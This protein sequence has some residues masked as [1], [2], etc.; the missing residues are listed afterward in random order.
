MGFEYLDNLSEDAKKDL[1]Q[2]IINKADKGDLDA[3]IYLGGL[4]Q[5][6]YM[7]K[8][9]IEKAVEV[10]KKAAE[11]GSGEAMYYLYTV[12]CDGGG[13]IAPDEKLARSYLSDSLEKGYHAAYYSAGRLYEFGYIGEDSKAAVE[14]YVKGAILG[15][16]AC[17]F[18]CGLIYAEGKLVEFDEEK[19]VTMIKA[20]AESGDEEAQEYIEKLEKDK[21]MIKKNYSEQQMYLKSFDKMLE[22]AN[23]DDA[24]AMFN[25]AKM[26]QKGVGVPKNYGKAVDWYLKALQEG[27][28]EAGFVLGAMYL[29][30]Q[31]SLSEN[32]EMA[33]SC[34]ES[35]AEKGHAR[36]MIGI[37][38]IYY[39]AYKVVEQ[40][41]EKASKYHGRAMQ[42]NDPIALELDVKMKQAK[43]GQEMGMLMFNTLMEI[44][45]V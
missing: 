30:G 6:G 12:Y 11:Q 40:D 34:W 38:V 43:T 10:W 23:A 7:V 27:N 36:A 19:A 2:T 32:V 18:R 8:R 14:L 13:Q 39:F 31:I 42:L 24:R 44:I 5:E 21:D 3:L 33:L 28:L 1:L 25:I 15:N 9:D 16:A 17:M 37:A 35:V 4:Y 29:N 26:Y 20:A 41:L 45:K 22:K